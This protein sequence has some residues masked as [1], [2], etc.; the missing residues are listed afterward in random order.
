MNR[1][2]QLESMAVSHVVCD[3]TLDRLEEITE[4]ADLWHH[5]E[6]YH[7]EAAN[8]AE[9]IHGSL[10]H[11]YYYGMLDAFRLQHPSLKFFNGMDL[12]EQETL[13]LAKQY[14]NF[15]TQSPLSLTLRALS[16]LSVMIARTDQ[17][18][19]ASGIEKAFWGL[20]S[21]ALW[22]VIRNPEKGVAIR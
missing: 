19:E 3:D 11:A 5:F 2:E 9:D 10:Q 6:G 4:D 8:H 16:N 18:S 14:P 22:D 12:S 17:D 21:M 13:E 7:E 1:Q 15:F 20:V